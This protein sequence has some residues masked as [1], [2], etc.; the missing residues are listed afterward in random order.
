MR[1]TQRGFNCHRWVKFVHDN[2]LQKDHICIFELMKGAR[3]TTMVV[4]VLRKVDGRFVMV[5]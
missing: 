3:M 1:A 2:R 5:A 4:H